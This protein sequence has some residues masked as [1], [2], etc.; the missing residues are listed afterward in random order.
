MALELIKPFVL[1]L[2]LY[3]FLK[4]NFEVKVVCCMFQTV[5]KLLFTKAWYNHLTRWNFQTY[6]T[7]KA[8]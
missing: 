2:F 1:I 6:W 5:L 8:N 4:M 3:I 7:Q